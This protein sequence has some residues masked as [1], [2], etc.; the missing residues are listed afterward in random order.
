MIAT[1]PASAASAASAACI[2][3]TFVGIDVS[4][5]TLDLCCSDD[6]RAVRRFANDREGIARVV[7]LLKPMDPKLIVVESTG[8]LEQPLLLA[9]L[10]AG[11]PVARVDPKRVRLFAYG[12]GQLA[13]TD[14]IDA[15]VLAK[16]AELA[17][18]RLTER[19]APDR[20]ELAELLVCR[21]QLIDAR[22][23]HQNQLSR[24]TSRVARKSLESVL[25]HLKS[26]IAMLDREVAKV[27]DRDD[28]L[29]ALDG[30]LRSFKGVGPVLSATLIGQLPE[31]GKLGHAQLAAL[32][33]L[34]PYNRDS[35]THGGKRSIRG[36]RTRVRNVLYMCTVAA[37]RHNPVL[38][39]TYQRLRAAGKVAK[40]AIVACA[41][42]FL[43]ILN[44]MVRDSRTWTPNTHPQG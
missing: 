16:F 39:R 26:R 15:R 17:A 32:V 18:P 34:A 14:P 42:K 29:R 30:L 44:A 6:A 1:L 31:L 40:V 25:N 11:L 24:T 43:R 36:G 2:P 27:V 19:K 38:K 7:A 41:R 20:A 33:G 3:A 22:T 5:A 12:I 37:L 4:A 8:K 10:D 23:A 21:Q 35:G 13:K 9:L 28:D